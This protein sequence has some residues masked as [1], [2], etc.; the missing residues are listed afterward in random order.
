MPVLVRSRVVD[1]SPER[2]WPLIDAVERH[3]E[4]DAR[5][6]RGESLESGSATVGVGRRERLYQRVLGTTF[7]MDLVVTER[8]PATRIAW[9]TEAWRSEGRQIEL[10]PQTLSF[11]LRPVEGGTRIEMAVSYEFDRRWQRVVSRM[12]RR[13][14]TAELDRALEQLARLTERP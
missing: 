4:W 3:R 13:W 12:G 5:V 7:E 2:L 9:R 1:A 6:V 10:K 11:D 8:E 14:E